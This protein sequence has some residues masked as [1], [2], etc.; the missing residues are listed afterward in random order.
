[1]TSAC[2]RGAPSANTS[3]SATTWLV[4]PRQ[5]QTRTSW[6]SSANALASRTGAE[7][8][9]A[10]PTPH[11][12]V[13]ASRPRAAQHD[14]YPSSRRQLPVPAVSQHTQRSNQGH[15]LCV[16][17][18]RWQT[19]G[20]REFP[21]QREWLAP[22]T[23]LRCGPPLLSFLLPTKQEHGRLRRPHRL[24]GSTCR[25]SLT[26]CARR[27]AQSPHRTPVLTLQLAE[28]STV[29]SF[30]D[31]GRTTHALRWVRHGQCCRPCSPSL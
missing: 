10:R 12:S 25:P 21:R 23:L 2:K 4:A 17:P 18:R 6:R 8:D 16:E 3:G 24:L 14:A 13:A 9:V 15:Q 20:T 26:A 29:H 31:F 22:P 5:A 19:V 11:R 27:R 7:C 30:P 28:S 1:M